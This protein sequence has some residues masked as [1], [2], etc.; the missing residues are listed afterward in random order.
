MEEATN[1]LTAT[2]SCFRYTTLDY[3]YQISMLQSKKKTEVLEALLGMIN[4]YSLFFHEGQE[5]YQEVDVFSQQLGIEID[6]MR[7]KTN[8]LNKQMEKRHA[9]VGDIENSEKTAIRIEGYLFKRGQNAFR[10]WNRRW[11]YLEV[12]QYFWRLSFTT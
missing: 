9:A 5:L 7:T 1:L 8:T 6:V 11:F 2:Q 12:I 4:S 10:T 3:V